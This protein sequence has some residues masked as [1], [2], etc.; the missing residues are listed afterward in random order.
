M[1]LIGRD[2]DAYEVYEDIVCIDDYFESDDRIEEL[3][4]TWVN[5][6]VCPAKDGCNP[7]GVP[8]TK[9]GVEFSGELFIWIARLLL[10]YGRGKNR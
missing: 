8:H 3:T 6:I 1:C 9:D 4:Q 2:P 7:N 10:G 5:C